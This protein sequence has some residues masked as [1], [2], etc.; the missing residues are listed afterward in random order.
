MAGH[1]SKYH[2]AL[3]VS[4]HFYLALVFIFVVSFPRMK[5]RMKRTRSKN[6]AA[7]AMAKRRWKGTTKAQRSEHGTM[8][9]RAREE[10]K[11]KLQQ[12]AAAA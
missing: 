11:H 10:R 7:V 12:A 3:D 6:P 5:S 2:R 4:R 1:D 8:M 9:V